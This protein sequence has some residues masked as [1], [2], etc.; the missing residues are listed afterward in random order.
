MERLWSCHRCGFVNSGIIP[1]CSACDEQATS[2]GDA[3]DA[4]ML[5]PAPELDHGGREVTDEH[6]GQVV[7]E[8]GILPEVEMP[9]GALADPLAAFDRH[10]P[11][12]SDTEASTSASDKRTWEDSLLTVLGKLA[13]PATFLINGARNDQTFSKTVTSF[14]GST[15]D[16]TREPTAPA[17]RRH[18]RT[19]GTREP[20]PTPSNP[21]PAK[22]HANP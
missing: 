10:T 18:P 3:V 6:V 21:K 5:E 7:S 13:A 2:P 12:D 8:P 15:R 16:G 22:A 11:E 4:I 20:N 17:N 19:D 9:P 14:S 1:R